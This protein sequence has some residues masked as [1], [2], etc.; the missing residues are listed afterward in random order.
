MSQG[1]PRQQW[2]DAIKTGLEGRGEDTTRWKD[3]VQD[4]RRGKVLV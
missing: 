3:I 2:E 1:R 4:Q